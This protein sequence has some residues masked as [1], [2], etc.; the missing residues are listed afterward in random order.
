MLNKK[1]Y[2]QLIH[3]L[4]QQLWFF[5]QDTLDRENNLLEQYGFNRFRTPGHGGSS[6]YRIKWG[7][8]IV[9]LHS[10]CV[11]IYGNNRD[12]FLFV[13]AHDK[14]YAYLGQKPPLPGRYRNAFLMLPSDKESKRRFYEASCDFFEWLEHYESWIDTTHGKG[15]R[16]DCYARY[17]RKWLSPDKARMWFQEYRKL[18]NNMKILKTA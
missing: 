8:R 11:G 9:D 3:G 12:G 5:G 17:H 18:D 14:A 16:L 1:I 4:E 6:R 7:H 2:K 15:Y 13:R 10:F